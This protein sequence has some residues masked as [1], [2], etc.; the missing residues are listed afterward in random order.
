MARGRP[1][2][3][4]VA[5]VAS[6]T[7]PTR[8]RG[9]P[10][11]VE[12]TPAAA[13]QETPKKRG[14]PV[15]AE[16]APTAA[17]K[18]NVSKA[19]SAGRPRKDV[20]AP[21]LATRNSPRAKK[22]AAPPAPVAP[23][24]VKSRGR[25]KGVTK[26]AKPATVSAPRVNARV[27]SKLRDRQQLLDIKNAAAEKAKAEAKKSQTKT[28]RGRGLPRKYA[29]TPAPAAKNIGRKVARDAIQ[30]R[31]RREY[32]SM[33]LEVPKKFVA[34]VQQLVLDLEAEFEAEKAEALVQEEEAAQQEE[35]VNGD[36]EEIVEEEI[37]ITQGN[38]VDADD[39]DVS[40]GA[41]FSGANGTSD[42]IIEEFVEERSSIQIGSSSA[43]K[44]PS[45]APS[46]RYSR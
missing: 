32:T 33:N 46:S 1:A 24:A 30:K 27:R 12:A 44:R 19:R 29:A 5:A 13:P 9:R 17:P 41:E 10:K 3:T 38:I 7:T 43:G 39:M 34:R 28:G 4:T 35:Q 6:A 42:E 26:A 2:K 40:E 21:A 37:D 36:D 11:K 23:R 16:A 14:R 22:T 31:A 15:K 18:A 8:G 20:A 45:W 25:P